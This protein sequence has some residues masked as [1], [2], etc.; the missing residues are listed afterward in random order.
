ML[1]NHGE[2]V[3]AVNNNLVL[4]YA[5]RV[6][7]LETKDK[8][9]AKLKDVLG[10]AS[11]FRKNKEKDIADLERSMKSM[12][13]EKEKEYTK[14][15]IGYK[16]QD[17]EKSH[18]DVDE[19]GSLSNSVKWSVRN[20]VEDAIKNFADKGN[21]TAQK[22]KEY[23]NAFAVIKT[24]S[25]SKFEEFDKLAK[26]LLDE[27][28]TEDV[29]NA[30]CMVAATYDIREIYQALMNAERIEYLR[31]ADEGAFK[32]L[33]DIGMSDAIPDVTEKSLSSI[34]EKMKMIEAAI[35]DLD[36]DEDDIAK[37]ALANL[38]SEKKKLENLEYEK[39]KRKA[40]IEKNILREIPEMDF[41]SIKNLPDF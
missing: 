16:K 15:K 19:H 27:N 37:K 21:K 26:K 31:H 25:K 34:E 8:F 4:Q 7:N 22:V 3:A 36:V 41:E 32:K 18:S 9:V 11:S 1:K 14:K 12:K 39:K 2:Y 35:K 13:S 6:W 33:R 38:E 20:D 28:E 30:V 29:R 10:N 17:I 40:S 5:V 24:S 23:M